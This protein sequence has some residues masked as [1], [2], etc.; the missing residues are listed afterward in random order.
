[1]SALYFATWME[2]ER[3][4]DDGSH[5]V[6][7]L[8]KKIQSNLSRYEFGEEDLPPAIQETIAEKLL[9]EVV[10]YWDEY[11]SVARPWLEELQPPSR[12]QWKQR[13]QKRRN[14]PKTEPLSTDLLFAS[15]NVHGAAVRAFCAAAQWHKHPTEEIVYGWYREFD[16]LKITIGLPNKAEAE[17]LWQFLK[18]GGSRMVKAH[19]ALWGRW[20][21]SGGSDRCQF[22][23]VNINQFCADL[24]YKRHHKGGYR[25]E[26]RQ[27]A[28][29]VLEALTSVEVRATWLAPGETWTKPK[30]RRLR[31][32]L[33]DRGL[34][35]EEKD[36]YA[37][38]FGQIR[39]GDP[40]LW[41]PLAF[42]FAPGPWFT[43]V[44]WRAYNHAVGKIGSGLMKL[45]NRYDEW[46]ILIGGY[47]GTQVRVNHYRMQPLK[48]ETILRETNLAQTAD[49]RRRTSETETKF[50][51]ALDR[52]AEIGVIASWI[53]AGVNESHEADVAEVDDPEAIAAY[54]TQDPLPPFWNR[55]VLLN[56]PAAFEADYDRLQLQKQKKVAA[57]ASKPRR[58]YTTQ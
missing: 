19:Y 27:E 26:H 54:Y 56:L 39:E 17:T 55:R 14:A 50:E 7:R 15:D 38:L 13:Q 35:A 25:P 47:L 3:S 44:E 16:N 46:A 48:V 9:K 29:K 2:I 11:I 6:L 4:F 42:S 28:I 53:W 41:E 23:T 1:M 40:D 10:R 58:R 51:R 33:W 45:D 57:A 37:D 49:A 34:L 18:A 21:E 32:P 5:E 24:N 30:L 43:N 8:W 52:L 20:Y 31:G 12:E 22:V 36:V